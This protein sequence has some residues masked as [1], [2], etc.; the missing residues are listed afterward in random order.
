M[1]AK[2]GIGSRFAC[3]ALALALGAC[4]SGNALTTAS[5]FG[6]SKEKAA[7]PAPTPESMIDRVV[8]VGTTSAR[9]QRCGYVFDP[10]ALRQSYLAFE[11]QQGNTP[12]QLAR[13]EKSYDY[14]FA[15]VAKASAAD[16]D[17]CSE[18]KTADI[19][20]DL[21]R[22]LA[23]DYSTSIRKPAA[24][25]GWWTPQHS[26]KPMNREEVFNPIR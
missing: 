9:A 5:F 20:R 23:G 17:Y 12:E 19:K 7:A 6:S 15:S 18:T 11:S 1:H 24:N 4:S 21:N 3:V 16:A 26:E 2:S 8:H 22:A 10:A 14:T 13:A 25:V